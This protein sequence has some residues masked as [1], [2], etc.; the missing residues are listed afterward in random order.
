M[1][2]Y[3]TRTPLPWGDAI[4]KSSPEGVLH[5]SNSAPLAAS[6]GL[7]EQLRHWAAIAPDRVLLAKREGSK[8]Q[9]VTYREAL[10]AARSIG[11][12]LL[13]RGLSD[14]K[15]VM[16][17]SGN[18][19]E[20]GLL[21][22]A[23]LQVGIPFVPLSTAYSLIS[24]D[25]AKLHHIIAQVGPGL[26]F[27]DEGES[28][29]A[30][31]QSCVP[32]STEVVIARGY[33]GRNAT[34]F[35]TL[36][37]TSPGRAVESAYLS[38]GPDTIAKLLFT[39]GSTGAPKGVITTHRMW[40]SAMQ[41]TLVCYPE[42]NGE[43][44]VLVDWLPWNHIFGGT[45]SFGM[46]LFSGGTLYID[47]GKPVPGQ[48]QKTV[49]NLRDVAP[50]FYSNVP[51]GFEELIPYLSQDRDLR[52]SFFHRLRILQYAGASIS[53]AVLASF[54]KLALDTV[55][56]RIPWVGVLGSTEAGLVAAHRH[57]DPTCAGRVGL[58][59]PGV[60]LKLTPADGK[61]EL[62]IKSASVTPGY[63]RQDDLTAAAFDKDGYF[64][65]GDGLQWVDADDHRS[66]FRYDGRLAE[67]F[68]LATGTWVRV[69]K[70]RAQLLDCLLPDLRD[71]VIAGEGRDYIVVLGIPASPDVAQ[72]SAVRA[73][74]QSK[75]DELGSNASGSAQRVLRFAFLTEKLSIDAGELTDK[76]AIS[77]RNII[78][79][80]AARIE[81]LY[82]GQPNDDVI[83]VR[84]NDEQ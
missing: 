3:G 59:P 41:M 53:P 32:Q 30:A 60:T 64:R 43:P 12:A 39:S 56:H 84:F 73:R 6:V 36:L 16:I 33:V 28:Y 78:R 61:L 11:Q 58:P 44:P 23:C 57:S 17:L 40:C 71:L 25:F 42:L 26:V 51:K 4:F 81:R 52:K 66:G 83:C 20:H 8:W 34:L 5:V 7:I 72:D 1:T 15:P 14:L 9:S 65:S 70:L 75:L 67:D 74:L 80:H 76:G 45:F 82:D 35:D 63:W 29:A 54:D 55:G 77:Q 24:T 19:L 47:D 49:R 48:I 38:V 27:A 31:I 10:N 13:D 79:R 2:A 18:G 69:E 50:L 21:Q 62:W 68:K 22:L 37:A 46:T